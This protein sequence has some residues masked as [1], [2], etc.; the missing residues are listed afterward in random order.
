MST[1]DKTKFADWVAYRL[2]K[3]TLIGDVKTT[4]KWKAD[5]WLD[6]NETLE[7]SD[8]KGTHKVLKTDRGHIRHHLRHLKGLST[9][10]RP[11]IYQI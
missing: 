4:R 6:D 11:I 8:Y 9:G 2:D 5:P 3:D 7:P 10:M 1:N